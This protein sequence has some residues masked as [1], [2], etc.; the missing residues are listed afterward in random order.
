MDVESDESAIQLEVPPFSLERGKPTL[1]S[2]QDEFGFALPIDLPLRA[3]LISRHSALHPDQLGVDCVTTLIQPIC[4]HET[5]R[6]LVG[7]SPAGA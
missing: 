7:L 1:L 6:I 2:D 3:P 5:R 4:E